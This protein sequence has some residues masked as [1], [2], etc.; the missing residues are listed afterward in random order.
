MKKQSQTRLY[1]YLLAIQETRDSILSNRPTSITRIAR[2]HKISTNLA[3][4]MARVGMIVNNSENSKTPK[5]EWIYESM[6]FESDIRAVM[7]AEHSIQEENREK[8]KKEN[9]SKM[10]DMQPSFDFESYDKIILVKDGAFTVLTPNV[11]R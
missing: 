7:K 2:K 10:Q 3:Q 4:A 6:V 8:R 9:K 5:Y 1:R 11:S